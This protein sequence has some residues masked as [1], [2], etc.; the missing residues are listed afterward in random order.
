MV[1]Q[2][3]VARRQAI[4]LVIDRLLAVPK[5]FNVTAAGGNAHVVPFAGRLGHV[6]SRGDDVVKRTGR[7]FGRWAAVICD[8]WV[9]Y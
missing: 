7:A 9:S 1:L 3:D 4:R 5:D 8:A 6:F 2:A